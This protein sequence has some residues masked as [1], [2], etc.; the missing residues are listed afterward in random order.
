MYK[1]YGLTICL[2][3][4]ENLGKYFCRALQNIIIIS[5]VLKFDVATKTINM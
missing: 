1:K 4:Y 3:I 2:F 5:I